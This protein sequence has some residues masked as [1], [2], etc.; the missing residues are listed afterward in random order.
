MIKSKNVIEKKKIFTKITICGLRIVQKKYYENEGIKLDKSKI[1][2]NEGMRTIC[3]LLLNSFWGRFGMNSNKT[4][5]KLIRNPNEWFNL[6]S[7]DQYIVKSAD[8]THKKYLQVYYVHA[9]N[10]CNVM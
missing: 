10:T 2:K 5:Y 9:K 1:K 6:I 4:I 8:F 7:D 3:K